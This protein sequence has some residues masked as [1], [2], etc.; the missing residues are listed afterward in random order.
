[1][2]R[3]RQRRIDFPGRRWEPAE[4]FAAGTHDAFLV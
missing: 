2:V 3:S 4:L 1:V